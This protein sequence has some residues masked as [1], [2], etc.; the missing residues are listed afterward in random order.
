MPL[1]DMARALSQRSAD[2]LTPLPSAGIPKEIAPAI[3]AI[4][5][6]FG[7]QAKAELEAE[8]K[9]AAQEEMRR[10]AEAESVIAHVRGETVRNDDLGHSESK[11]S[12]R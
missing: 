4:N 11:S 3:E 1:S 5:D 2:E 6:L 10:R 9:A 12:S 8:A 7:R